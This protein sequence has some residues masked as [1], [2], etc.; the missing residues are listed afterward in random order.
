[1]RATFLALALAA[2][3]SPVASGWLEHAAELEQ[4]AHLDRVWC[5]DRVGAAIPYADVQLVAIDASAAPDPAAAERWLIGH[6]RP[7]PNGDLVR[8]ARASLGTRLEVKL[9]PRDGWAVEAKL[10]D[11]SGALLCEFAHHAAAGDGEAFARALREELVA[12]L[13]QGPPLP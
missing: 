12:R 6:L 8:F 13:D 7:G 10:R 2:C 1:M 11:W 5:G 4:G 9:T 3:A